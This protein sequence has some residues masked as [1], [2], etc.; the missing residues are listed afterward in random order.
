MKYFRYVTI[1]IF[2]FNQIASAGLITHLDYSSGGTITASGQNTNENAIVNEFNGNIESANI[3]DAT[4]VN[5]D[6][7]NSTIQGGKI[8]STNFSI[9]V[10]TITTLTNTTMT[11]STATITHLVGTTTNN[12]ATAG[13]VGEYKSGSV[14]SGSAV[15]ASGTNFVD[16]TAITLTAGDWDLSGIVTCTLNAATMTGYEGVLSVNT[17]NTQ[18][19]HVSG[20]NLIGSNNVPNGVEDSSVSIPN[21]RV[22][23]ASTTTYYLKFRVISSAGTP[24]GYGRMSARRVR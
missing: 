4:I 9:S 20:D 13:T 3:K 14:V 11:S 1:L 23:I 24:K 12:N 7:A 19:D 22:S 16:I 10:A 17:G 6:I 18:T 21:W 8:D 15:S 2:T 5:A